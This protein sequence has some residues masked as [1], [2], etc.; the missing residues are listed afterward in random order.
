MTIQDTI[1][2][3]ELQHY[4]YHHTQ[5]VRRPLFDTACQALFFALELARL[6]FTAHARLRRRNGRTV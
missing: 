2:R 4:F 5:P 1:P 3:P 6:R